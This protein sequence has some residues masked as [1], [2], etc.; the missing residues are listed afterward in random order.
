VTGGRIAQGRGQEQSSLFE[1][2]AQCVL[3]EPVDHEQ[4]KKSQN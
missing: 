4:Q 1:L 3:G 2:M